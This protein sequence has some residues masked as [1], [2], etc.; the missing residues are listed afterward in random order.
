[1]SAALMRTKGTMS[2]CHKVS[3]SRVSCGNT[4]WLSPSTKPCPGKC[5]P[6]LLMP[7]RFRPLCKAKAKSLTSCASAEK[8]RLPITAHWS[9]SK[10]STGV[11]DKSMPHARNS[12]AKTQPISS[13][14]AK[15][16]SLP[17][18]CHTSFSTAIAG[19]RV[20]P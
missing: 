17:C 8:L 13:A 2:F 20:K 5:L 6:Q 19:K 14:C 15:A 10:S 11:N 18:V 12:A 16:A 1:M 3:K 7:P 9:Q 4:W